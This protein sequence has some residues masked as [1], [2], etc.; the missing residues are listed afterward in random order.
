MRFWLLAQGKLGPRY[1][2]GRMKQWLGML[3]RNYVQAQALFVAL[4]GLQ[5]CAAIDALLIASTPPA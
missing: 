2:P 1:A 5:D 4:R 3:T